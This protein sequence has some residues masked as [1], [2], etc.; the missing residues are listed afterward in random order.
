[1]VLTVDTPLSPELAEDLRSQPGFY[2]VR[3]ITLRE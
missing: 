1:M 3:L 2:D